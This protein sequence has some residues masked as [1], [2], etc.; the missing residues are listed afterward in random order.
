VRA[1]VISGAIIV[2]TSFVLVVALLLLTRNKSA[3][4]GESCAARVRGRCIELRDLSFAYRMLRPTRSDAASRKMHLRRVALD[5]LIEREL[6]DD[7]A[8]RRGLRI[9]DQELTDQLQAGFVR[10]SVPAGDPMVTQQVLVDMYQAYLR[11]GV[12]SAEVAKA[13]Y[14]DRDTT[15]PVDFRDPETKLFDTTVYERKVRELSNRSTTEFREDQR[16]ELLAARVRDSVRD[17]VRLAENEVWNE[18]ERDKSTATL[19]Y[20]AVTEAWAQRWAVDVTEAD[21]NLWLESHQAALDKAV[22]VRKNDDT[23][24]AG[25]I[26]HIL[27]QLP[28][29]ASDEQRAAA[30]AKASWAAARVRAGELFAEVARQTSDDID[31]APKGGDLGDDIDTFLP[32]IKAVAEKLRAGETSPRA[33]ETRFGLHLLERD[34][35]ARAAALEEQLRR[36]ASHELVAKSKALEA[37]QS[38]ARKMEEAMHSGKPA[39]DAMRDT[40]ALYVRASVTPERPPAATTFDAS[41]DDQRPRTQTTSAFNRGGVP[42]RGLTPEGAAR[43]MAFAFSGSAG[44]VMDAP[45]R[46]PEGFRVVVLEQHTTATRQDFDRDREAFEQELLRAKRDEALSLYVNRLREQAKAEIEIDESHADGGS[47]TDDEDEP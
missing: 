1:R 16:R 47:A 25:H 24:R 28:H 38:V 26:R 34:D 2:A 42:F 36:S 32:E 41:T 18:Y 5:G 3:S 20:I 6:L 7:D 30:R 8:R 40:I 11:A 12:V 21:I 31:T 15:I 29:G 46:A 23:P 37:A 19:T 22:D 39:E 44:D 9:T 43:L 14:Y 17:P 4:P 33:V 10:V 45:L 35:P 13:H 27:V